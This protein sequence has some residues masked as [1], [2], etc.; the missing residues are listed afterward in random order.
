M[1][2]TT[3]L[4]FTLIAQTKVTPDVTAARSLAKSAEA[5]AD[6]NQKTKKMYMLKGKAWSAMKKDSDHLKDDMWREDVGWV[7]FTWA[8][9]GKV[10]IV[11]F[12]G[13]SPSGDWSTHKLCTYR[14]DGSLARSMYRYAAFMMSG[15]VLEE[16]SIYNKQGKKVFSQFSLADLNDNKVKN[17]SEQKQMLGFR[18]VLKD[19][20][21]SSLLPFPKP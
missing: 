15:R 13:G 12:T 3:A 7:A 9:T 20:L 17:A 14:P 1:P 21:K 11:S 10:L 2:V 5:Y 19:Y 8:K 16:E 4:V 18:P 6:K